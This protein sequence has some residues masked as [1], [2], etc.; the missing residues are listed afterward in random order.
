MPKT[1]ANYEKKPLEKFVEAV[2]FNLSG[3]CILYF[4]SRIR[5][6]TSLFF[7]GNFSR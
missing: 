5:D 3:T 2:S 7:F 1:E 6:K 4:S